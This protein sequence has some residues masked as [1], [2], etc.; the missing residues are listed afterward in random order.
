M[1]NIYSFLYE[2]IEKEACNACE[3]DA[4]YTDKG[5]KIDVTLYVKICEPC[6]IDVIAKDKDGTTLWMKKSIDVSS[7][8][9][10]IPFT[11]PKEPICSTL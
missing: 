6:C 10:H 5:K 9:E 3:C 7:E 11:E 2:S 1:L 4:T 8:S